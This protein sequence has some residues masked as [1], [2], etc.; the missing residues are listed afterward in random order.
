MKQE[1]RI[2]NK[3]FRIKSIIRNS[4][5]IIRK[6]EGFT[7][8]ELLI[9][10]VIIGVL[11]TILVS[12]FIGVRQRARD[13]Q[14]KSDLRQIQAALELYRHDQGIYP[15]SLYSTNNCPASSSLQAGTPAVIYMKKIP[16]DPSLI[17][18]GVP[19]PNGNYLYNPTI[20]RSSYFIIACIENSND[21]GPNTDSAGGC[22]SGKMYS[23]TDP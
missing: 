21:T 12:N 11:S 5:L 8:I 7:L 4:L 23:L 6:S 2:R 20:D 10:I 17:T 1:L 9:V 14:R 15:A 18:I 22:P 3:K 16:C 13:S 19:G